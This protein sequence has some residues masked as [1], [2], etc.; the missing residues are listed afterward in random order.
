MPK[1]TII[2][3]LLT[4]L[5]EKAKNVSAKQEILKLK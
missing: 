4:L 1:S 3:W 5:P 2:E